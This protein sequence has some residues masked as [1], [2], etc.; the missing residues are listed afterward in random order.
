MQ[1]Q[2]QLHHAPHPHPPVR[3]PTRWARLRRGWREYRFA[4]ALVLPALVFMVAIHFFP[5][6]QGIWMSFLKLNQFTLAQ[7]LNAPWVGLQNYKDVLF[8]PGNPVRAGLG[9][10][11]R[12]TVLYSFAVTI[13]T[14]AVGM[15]GA[16]LMNRKFPGQGFA[17]TTLLLPWVVPSYVV[18]ILWGFMWQKDNG[19]INTLLVDVLHLASD[20]PFWLIGSNTLWAIIIPTIWRSWPFLMVVFLAGLQTIP[21]EL[22]EAAKIDGANVLRQFWHITLPLLRPI[23]AIQLLFQIIANVYSYN[24]VAM[25]FGNGAGYPGEWGDLLMTALVRQTFGY[26]AFGTGSAAS[27]ILM[28]FMLIVVSI[29]YRAFRKEMMMQ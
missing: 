12:N 25:M 13:G 27:F 17:R 8:D 19:V 18:G 9:I 20:K 16:L 3:R 11:V 10:A 7:Y 14:L 1:E 21:E 23:I 29:W 24:I 15:M 26:W 4:Y 5:M 6:V 22:Y 28:L 2:P